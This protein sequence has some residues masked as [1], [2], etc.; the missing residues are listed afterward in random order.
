MLF[1]F[2]TGFEAGFHAT[3]S[4]DNFVQVSQLVYLAGQMTVF[5]N[6][7]YFRLFFGASYRNASSGL[8]QWPALRLLET[9]NTF[10]TQ[11]SF[12]FIVNLLQILGRS[13]WTLGCNS[14]P[15]NKCLH[16]LFQTSE[17][18]LPVAVVLSNL[19]TK[20]N[21]LIGLH[22]ATERHGLGLSI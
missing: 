8:T 16:R 20:I 13:V 21:Q 2:L 19:T 9:K 12:H 3:S 5:R 4:P 10:V 7:E 11:K 1:H 6:I 18:K 22:D 17:H 14:A 15:R